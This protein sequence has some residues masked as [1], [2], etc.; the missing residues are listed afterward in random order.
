MLKKSTVTRL[1]DHLGYLLRFVS[2]HVSQAFRLKLETLGVAVVEW[3]V[4]RMLFD[5]KRLNPGVLAERLEMTR[6]AISKLVDRLAA[7]RLVACRTEKED[8]RFQSLTLTE[9][10]RKL[11]PKL[12]AL[13]D[14]NDEE[15]FGHLTRDERMALA[16]IL[17]EIMHRGRLRG[18]PVD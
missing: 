10:G 13:A 18:V 5:E 16:G 6:G 17:N 11:V 14:R 7:K 3:V 8:R 1:D 9:V 2:N 15:F 12:A 4:L